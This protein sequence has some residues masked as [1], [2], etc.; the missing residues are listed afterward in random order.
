MTWSCLMYVARRTLKRIHFY[1]AIPINQFHSF[2]CVWGG[3]TRAF[4]GWD[5]LNK[6]GLSGATLIVKYWTKVLDQSSF[7][8]QE[9][10]IFDAFWIVHFLSTYKVSVCYH[11]WRLFIK[12]LIKI[13]AEWICVFT[14]RKQLLLFQ[15]FFLLHICSYVLQ[16]WCL[17]V[18]V[19]SPKCKQ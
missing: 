17:N 9:S 8:V 6:I 1:Y 15:T 13:R 12:R 16:F 14:R 3:V 11:R 5:L 18:F 4:Y 2:V 7:Y 10:L 19:I